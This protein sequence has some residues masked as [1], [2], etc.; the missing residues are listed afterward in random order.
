[1]TTTIRPRQT[2]ISI[3]RLLEVRSDHGDQLALDY[4]SLAALLQYA[5]GLVA[6]ADLS[7]AWQVSQ[8]SVSRR[9]NALDRARLIDVSGSHGAYQVNDLELL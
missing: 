1:M 3:R 5:P 8:S 6:T 2:A 9:I 7:A 4:L